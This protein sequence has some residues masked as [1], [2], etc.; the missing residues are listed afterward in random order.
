MYDLYNPTLEPIAKLM[1]GDQLP[2]VGP[3][4]QG[5][6]VASESISFVHSRF[7]LA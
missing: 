4:P 2:H 5:V 3:F 1:S 6:C 7:I